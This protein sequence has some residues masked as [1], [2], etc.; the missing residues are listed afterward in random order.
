MTLSEA[1][2][3]EVRSLLQVRQTV[4][5]YAP[6]KNPIAILNEKLDGLNSD[7][8]AEVQEI[9]TEYANVKFDTSTLQ[10]EYN[11]DPDRKR[12]LLRQHL[13]T[14]LDFDP[15]DY[16]GDTRLEMERGS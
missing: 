10:G 6:G 14:V 7:Q 15:A 13:I 9:L 5:Y 3:I 16:A 11:D 12:H 8:I 2:K 1:Q 4:A